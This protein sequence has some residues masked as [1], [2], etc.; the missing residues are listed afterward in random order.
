M[1]VAVQTLSPMAYLARERKSTIKSDYIDGQLYQMAGA[2]L[3]H[4][5]ILS[6]TLVELSIHFRQQKNGCKV[7]PSD[8]RVRMG[9]SYTYPDIVIICGQPEVESNDI[10][11]NPTIVIEVLSPSTEAYDRGAKSKKFRTVESLKEYALI[12]QDSPHIEHYIRQD[13]NQWL[14]SEASALDGSLYLPSIDC[15]L[16]LADIY[17]QIEFE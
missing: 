12:S 10:L 4:N 13:N 11:V 7:L 15:T 3:N 5:L 2:S 17:Q 6:D 8:M 1:S 14:F 16:N 9:D